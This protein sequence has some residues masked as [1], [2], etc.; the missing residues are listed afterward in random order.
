MVGGDRF[1]L[2]N[3][4]A[5]SACAPPTM[6]SMQARSRAVS[7]PLASAAAIS[8]AG[9]G[10]RRRRNRPDEALDPDG[11]PAGGQRNDRLIGRAQLATSDDLGDRG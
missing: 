7:R 10:E 4:S 1:T 6:V 9:I 2:R 11:A 5:G 3:A 8:A